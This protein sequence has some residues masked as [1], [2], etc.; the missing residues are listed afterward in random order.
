MIFFLCLKKQIRSV[1]S[2]TLKYWQR[3]QTFLSRGN[4]I[5]VCFPPKTLIHLNWVVFSKV[6]TICKTEGKKKSILVGVKVFFLN[7]SGNLMMCC[8]WFCFFYLCIFSFCCFW[9]SS[10]P[11]ILLVNSSSNSSHFLQSKT[12]C[13]SF[14]SVWGKKKTNPNY[15][16]LYIFITAL[17]KRQL[18]FHQCWRQV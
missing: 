1:V 2:L 12:F 5:P 8:L 11:C 3:F 4:S 6:P 15:L 7:R 16:S 13:F 18:Q 10:N 9:I 14:K 17:V